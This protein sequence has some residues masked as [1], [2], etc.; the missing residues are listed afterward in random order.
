MAN[1]DLLT[2]EMLSRAVNL[3]MST[4]KV[5]KCSYSLAGH[6]KLSVA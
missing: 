2:Q 5:F 1:Q 3:K 6:G 4:D